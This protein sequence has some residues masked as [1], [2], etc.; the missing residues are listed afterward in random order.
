MRS[1]TDVVR[2]FKQNW[3]EELSA[4]AIAQVCREA[5]MTWRDTTLSPIVTIQIFFLQ[6][7]H[8]NTA[9]EHLSHLTGMSF[10]AAAYCKARMR[11]ELEVL[12]ALLARCVDKLHQETFDAGRWLGHRVFHVDGS[13]ALTHLGTAQK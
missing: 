11:V 13:S 1:I 10:T 2:H 7:L 6:V 3:T 5:G 9:C 12:R 8:S 4:T